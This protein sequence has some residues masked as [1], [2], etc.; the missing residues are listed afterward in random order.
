MTYLPVT[1]RAALLLVFLVSVAAKARGRRH[2]A[3]FAASVAPF[4]GHR[5]A[6]AP[7]VVAGVAAAVTATEAA[8]VVLL[9]LPATARA[10]CVIAALLLAGFTVAAAV[11]VG[12]G[13]TAYCRCFDARIRPLRRRHV[14]RNALLLLVALGGCVADAVNPAR[15]VQPAGVVIAIVAGGIA[16]LILI[17]FDDLVEL[18]RP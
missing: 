16:A 10:G 3:A 17:N 13:R 9:V 14:V 8:C 12:T 18:V 2:Y 4:L 15:T 7:G 11:V 1:A 5:L 6:R